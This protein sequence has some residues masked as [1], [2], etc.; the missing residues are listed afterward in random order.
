MSVRER[1]GRATAGKLVIV[2]LVAV[3]GLSVIAPS[4]QRIVAQDDPTAGGAAGAAAANP[5]GDNAGGAGDNGATENG[6][7]DAGANHPETYLDFALAGGK[8]MAPIGICSL[9]WLTFL[10]ERLIALRSG[11]VLPGGLVR[12]FVA[13]D[14][15]RALDRGVVERLC[16]RYRSS[17]SRVLEVALAHLEAPR[18]DIEHAVN[19]VAQR[20]VHRLRRYLRLFSVIAGIAP[21]LGLLGTVTGMIQAFR[22]V[23]ISGLGSGQALAP[24]IYQALITTAAGLIIA[25]PAL[26]THHWFESK[27]DGYVHRIDTLVV[28]FVEAFGPRRKARNSEVRH[29]DE[30]RVATSG[31]G[32]A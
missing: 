16:K 2:S 31:A 21:L 26:I 27:I 30:P 24:G 6:S 25:I 17:A 9:L 22:E 3:V 1:A 28:D 8:L 29:S 20:E 13:I 32:E 19:N 11:R 7:G 12:G 14:K 23:A 10:V 18:E 4:I 5:E 15:N